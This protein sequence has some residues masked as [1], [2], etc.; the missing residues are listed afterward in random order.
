M[1][2]VHRNNRWLVWLSF[3]LAMV[4]SIM[5][6]PGSF[7]WWR[8]EWPALV[9][10]F[11]AMTQPRSYGV[12]VGWL[13]GLLVDVA[14][15]A[16]LGQYALGYALIAFITVTLYRRIRV[17]PVWQQAF[18]VMTMIVLHLSLSMWVRGVSGEDV[19]GWRYWGPAVSSL[20]VWPFIYLFLRRLSDLYKVA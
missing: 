15:G 19:G 9:L 11:W 4:F 14:R 1:A 2:R 13:L 7:A 5:P 10:V 18:V 6:L 16:L 3:A 20:I 12:G 17:F 8:P